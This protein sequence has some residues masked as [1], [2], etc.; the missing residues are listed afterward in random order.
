[1]IDGWL[2]LIVLV[3]CSRSVQIPAASPKRRAVRDSSMNTLAE[4]L[5]SRSDAVLAFLFPEICR[6]AE[7]NARRRKMDCLA[8]IAAPRSI[9]SN[10]LSASAADFPIPATSRPPLNAQTA[11]RWNC[12]SVPPGRQ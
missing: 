11:V 4:M 10:H 3:C 5:Q 1:M 9:L 6:V 12:I 8:R 2:A 7:Q